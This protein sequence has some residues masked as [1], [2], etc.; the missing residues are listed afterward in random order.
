L[1]PK[2]LPAP[3]WFFPLL[4]LRSPLEPNPPKPVLWFFPAVLPP[5]FPVGVVEVGRFTGGETML[6]LLFS[7]V[8]LRKESRLF[9]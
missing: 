4:L 5:D 9:A 6:L 8:D 2:L 3:L 1:R 7:E